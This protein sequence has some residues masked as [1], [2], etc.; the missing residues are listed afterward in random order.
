M[1]ILAV[2]VNGYTRGIAAR[3]GV[4]IAT[5]DGHHRLAI[6]PLAGTASVRNLDHL[7]AGEFGNS[8]FDPI[9]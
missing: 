2:I 4:V 1:L 8:E 3:R 6:R 7:V 9:I 5:G